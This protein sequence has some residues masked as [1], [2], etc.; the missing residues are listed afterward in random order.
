MIVDD[1]ALERGCFRR[2][3]MQGVDTQAIQKR[4]ERRKIGQLIVPPELAMASQV[5]LATSN[6]FGKFD[7]DP[8]AGRLHKCGIPIN[9]A[10]KPLKFCSSVPERAGQ[11]VEEIRL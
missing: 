4:A 11:V 7:L 8:C 2:K 1:L 3:G 9:S 10:S 6:R 5:R